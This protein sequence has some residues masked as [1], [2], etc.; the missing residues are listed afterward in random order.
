[1]SRLNLRH[2]ANRS[3]TIRRMSDRR[4]LPYPFGSKE[5]LENIE[6]HQLACPKTDHRKAERRDNDRRSQERRLSR[7]SDQSRSEI[8]DTQL[9]LSPEERLMIQNLYTSEVN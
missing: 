6:I 7:V 5:W 4:N 8:N 2:N 3:S 9:S 1:M